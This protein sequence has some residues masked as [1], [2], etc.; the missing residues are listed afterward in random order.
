MIKYYDSTI[1]MAELPDEIA[2]ALNISNCPLNCGGCSEP[3]L[4]PDVGTPL[5]EKELD[6]I[7]AKY[8]DSVTCICFMGGDADHKDVARC[9]SYIKSHSS[10]KTAIYSGYDFLDNDLLGC[11]DYYKIGRWIM[12]KGDSKDWWK[13]N[14]GPLQFPFSNQLLFEKVENKWLNITYKFRTHPL[15]ID[16]KKY[17]IS[18]K[19]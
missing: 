6:K 1:V 17:V 3:W 7:I 16:L 10:L 19:N 12:P 14:C 18:N 11:L 15:S 4:K 13:T 2:L 9:C 5:T 8:K